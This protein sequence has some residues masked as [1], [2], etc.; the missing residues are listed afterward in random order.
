MDARVESRDT[1]RPPLQVSQRLCFLPFINQNLSRNDSSGNANAR[2]KTSNTLLA[3]LSIFH[4]NFVSIVPAISMG[5]FPNPV[6]AGCRNP[7]TR[8]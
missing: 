5:I 3:V 4:R 1:G 6:F 7:T 8:S 2:V